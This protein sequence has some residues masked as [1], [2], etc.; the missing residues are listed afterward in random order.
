MSCHF[1]RVSVCLI[2]G[3]VSVTLLSR[4]VFAADP[5]HTACQTR[6]TTFEGWAADEVSNQWL[7]LERQ[8]HRDWLEHLC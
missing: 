6:S 2:L 4:S 7:R 8:R 3:L 5:L 1:N